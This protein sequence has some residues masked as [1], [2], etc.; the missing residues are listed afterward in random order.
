MDQQL[1]EY[2][3]QRA[4]AMPLSGMIVWILLFA[5]SF[6]LPPSQLVMAVFIGT[7]SIV[8]LAMGISRLTGE[9]MSF[10]KKNERNWFDNVFLASVGMSFLTFAI[11]IPFSME[12]YLTLPF[13][14]AVQT[15][16]MWLV[17]GVVAAQKIAI[18]RTLACVAAFMHWPELSFQLQPLIVVVCYGF[19]IPVMER[20]WK[21]QQNLCASN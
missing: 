3:Q 8:Y 18:V 11:T 6:V 10:K 7:G 12:N 14:L 13:A 17:Y 4:L 16:L 1:I 20:R 19:S 5:L 21:I 2:R 9:N 15:G